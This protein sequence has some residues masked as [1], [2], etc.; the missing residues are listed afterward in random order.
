MNNLYGKKSVVSSLFWKFL[1]RGGSQSIQFI[2][3]IILAR[4]LS[5]KEFGTIAIVI[6]FIDLAQVFV[7]GGFNTALIQKKD[8]DKLDFSSIFY[9]SLIISL[10]SYILIYVCSPFVAEYYNDPNL[11]SVLRTLA[12]ILFPGALNS[13]QNAYVSK[14]MLFKVLF[15]CSL[16]ATVISGILG[17][18]A[19]NIGFGVWSLV[20]QQL[21]FHIVNSIVLWITVKWRPELIF[22]FERVKQLFSFGSRVLLA[23]FVYRF[24][25]NLR[26]L[27]IGRVYTPTDLAFYQRGEQIPR[28]MVNNIDGS[29]QSVILPT[30]AGIQDD[31]LRVKNTV[32]RTVSISSYI[33]FPIMIGIF[34]V[35]KPL[36][37]LLLTEKWIA[38]VPFLQIFCLTYALWPLI[39]INLQPI[40]ALGR[41]DLILKLEVIKRVIGIIIIGVSL[42]YGIYAV[43]IGAFLER[44][45]EVII[46]AI[47]NKK[48]IQYGLFE[49]FGDIFPSLC[50]SIIMGVVVYLL[51]YLSMSPMTLLVIQVITGLMTYMILSIIFKNK[52]F[53]YLMD[54]VKTF[55]K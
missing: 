21:T 30:L 39:T 18:L 4:L 36:V 2:V 46:N 48:L 9:L 17:I 55:K 11:V 29:I 26:V 3:Q 20:I 50:Q 47:P 45:I 7:Q 25:I 24:Y 54:T 5:P 13:V 37:I 32:K 16:I 19:A 28:V 38:A 33:I 10:L 35:A 22:S 31:I 1:E 6:V 43:A 44:F 51:S 49:Q 12:L 40:R 52:A 42:P 34:V 8:S 53:L 41:S 27:I 14:N 23:N 15:K